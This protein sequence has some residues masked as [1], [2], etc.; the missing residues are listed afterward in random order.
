MSGP[1]EKTV[2]KHTHTHTQ[3]VKSKERSQSNLPV[4]TET[5]TCHIDIFQKILSKNITDK[6]T[7]GQQVFNK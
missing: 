7:Y 2:R 1:L 3:K 4:H 6:E 5:P